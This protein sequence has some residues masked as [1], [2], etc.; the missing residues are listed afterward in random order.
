MNKLKKKDKEVIRTHMEQL[1]EGFRQ[2]GAAYVK[3]DDWSSG[4]VGVNA[5]WGASVNPQHPRK[6]C[7]Y[8]NW[9]CAQWDADDGAWRLCG[10]GVPIRTDVCLQKVIG[11]CR[12]NFRRQHTVRD[13]WE[14]CQ[15]SMSARRFGTY[16][17]ALAVALGVLDLP[18]PTPLKQ[19]PSRGRSSTPRSASQR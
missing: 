3:V 14:Q 15:A 5:Y 11:E 8:R 10:P 7:D 1:A 16:L 6:T 4:R 19:A 9:V 2:D 12:R 18:E 17:G 13:I